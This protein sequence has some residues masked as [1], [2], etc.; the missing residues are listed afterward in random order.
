MKKSQKSKIVLC[1]ILGLAAISIGSVGFATWLVGV[2]KTQET[3][4]VTAIV[5]NS[6]NDSIY[7]DVVVSNKKFVI[8][9]SEPNEKG[10]G[11]IVGTKANADDSGIIFNA[12]ALSFDFTT[13]EL[14]VG[15][16]VAD[17]EKP[18]KVTVQFNQTDNQTLNNW[19]ATDLIKES[20]YT[21]SSD[22]STSKLG[23]KRI[24]TEYISYSHV[25]TLTTDFTP[26]D[27]GSYTLYKLNNSFKTQHFFWGSFFTRETE[28]AVPQSPVNYYN[29]IY[30]SYNNNEAAQYMSGSQT[31]DFADKIHQEISA[32]NSCFSGNKELKIKAIAGR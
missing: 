10:D 22:G 32:L 7:L 27:K 17:N 2:N 9:E 8:A 4:K 24:G 13:F 14:S 12:N 16:G 18:T 1:S 28:S 29:G 15:K 30:S 20:M 6:Q 3:L 5:D 21:V 19:S 11:E 25:F 23:S 26:E 31:F